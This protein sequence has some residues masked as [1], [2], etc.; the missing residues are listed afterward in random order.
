MSQFRFRGREKKFF[1]LVIRKTGHSCSVRKR[2]DS[3]MRTLGQA[4]RLR[5]YANRRTKMT[6]LPRTTWKPARVTFLRIAAENPRKTG[7]VRGTGF[8]G[9]RVKRLPF[10]FFKMARRDRGRGP[11]LVK[12]IR[13]IISLTIIN[14]A[15]NL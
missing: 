3:R 11:R 8:S 12:S 1:L 4:P 15:K 2:V 13:I 10:G 9:H 5:D 6:L 14:Q 7:F